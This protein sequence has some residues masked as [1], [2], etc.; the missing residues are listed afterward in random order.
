MEDDVER[1]KRENVSQKWSEKKI[2]NSDNKA[3]T[4]SEEGS[5]EC[6]PECGETLEEPNEDGEV[7]VN[8]WLQFVNRCEKCDKRFCVNCLFY[9]SECFNQGEDEKVWCLSCVEKGKYVEC[10]CCGWSLCKEHKED[11][12]QCRADRNYDLRHRIF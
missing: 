7:E 4:M 6:C 10:K 3:C 11:C 12:G 9:C 8:E 2:H 1:D 5:D